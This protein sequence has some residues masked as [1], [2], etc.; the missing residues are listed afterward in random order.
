MCV[1]VRYSFRVSRTCV[2]TAKSTSML[3]YTTGSRSESR[4]EANP[5]RSVPKYRARVRV[6]GRARARRVFCILASVHYSFRASRT[7]VL[8]A[9]R[10]SKFTHMYTTGSRSESRHEANPRRSRPSAEL[11]LGSRYAH[12]CGAYSACV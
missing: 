3:M 8:T 9:K 4:H 5:R 6:E 7:C 2:S 1:S 10:T 11:G 12:V